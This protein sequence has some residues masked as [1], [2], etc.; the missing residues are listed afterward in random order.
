MR[1]A[2]FDIDGTLILTGGAGMRAFYRA[3]AQ[4]F[5]LAVDSEVI[6]PDGKTDPI[7]AL[8]MLRHFGRESL[9]TEESRQALFGCYLSCLDEEMLLAHGNGHVRV[10]PGVRDLLEALAARPDYSLGIVT[11]NLAAG[12]KIKLVRAGLDPYFGFGGYGSDSDDRTVL[13][14]MAMERGSQAVAPE[15][16]E[17]AIVIGDTP[18]DIIH[19]RAAGASVIGVA[20]A[21]YTM[22]ELAAHA[23][24]LLVSNLTDCAGI[25]AFMDSVG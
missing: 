12:A 16:V 23:P 25:L 13:I 4:V 18:L 20:S 11:G 2:L 21:R 24:D 22:D 3:L 7:I 14:R 19:G 9:W 8:E 17:A 10:L 15:R 1:L 6:R 5:S